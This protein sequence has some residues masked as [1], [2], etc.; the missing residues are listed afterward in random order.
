M[1]RRVAADKNALGE[2]RGMLS[3]SWTGEFTI[4]RNGQALPL[5]ARFSMLVTKRGGE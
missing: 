1:L 3:G 5:P 4:M 2:R